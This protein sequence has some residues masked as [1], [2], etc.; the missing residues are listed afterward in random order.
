[1]PSGEFSLGGQLEAGRLPARL[2]ESTSRCA[3]ER[4]QHCDDPSLPC[5]PRRPPPPAGSCP[6]PSPTSS[7]RFCKITLTTWN[8]AAIFCSRFAVRTIALAKMAR[9]RHLLR[10]ADVVCIQEAHGQPGDLDTLARE[11]PSHVHFGTFSTSQAAGG[12]LISLSNEFVCGVNHFEEIV[13]APGWCLALRCSGPQRAIQFINIHIEPALSHLAKSKLLADIAATADTFAGSTYLL[14][15]FN[16]VPSDEARYRMAECEDVRGDSKLALEFESRFCGF[17]ELHQAGYTRKQVTH[18]AITALSRLDRIYTNMQPCLLHD[19]NVHT[20]T[21]GYITDPTNI[22]D[23]IPVTTC[24][25]PQRVH[26]GIDFRLSSWT[27][28]HPEFTATTRD[29]LDTCTLPASGIQSLSILREVLQASDMA[30]KNLGEAEGASTTPQ[31]LYWALMAMRGGRDGKPA[32]ISRAVGAYPKLLEWCSPRPAAITHHTDLHNHITLLSSSNIEQMRN[33]LEADPS[34]AEWKK[35]GR[36]EALRRRA[37]AWASSRR[38]TSTFTILDQ[39]EA[40]ATSAG[41]ASQL[42]ANHW[43]AVF[44]AKRCFKIAQEKLLQFVV[45]APDDIDWRLPREEFIAIAQR[46][47]DSAPGPD[48]IPY[49][50]WVQADP[51]FIDCVHRAYDELLDGAMLPDDFND[52]H[53]VFLPKGEYDGDVHGIARTPEATRPLTL[54]N[55]VAKVL[56][57]AMN[58]SLSQMAAR[59]VSPRQRGFV[60]GRNLLDNVVETEA[61]AIHFAQYYGDTS[62]IALL[63]LVAAFPSL[64]HSWIFAVLRRMGVPRFF[65]RA[66]AKLYRMVNIKILFGGILAAGFTASS[67]IKQGCPASGSLF[68]IAL[69]PFLRMLCLRLPMPVSIVSAFADDIGIVTRQLLETLSVLAEL[70]ALLKTATAM[71][72]SPTKSVI[73]PLGRQTEEIITD[74][75]QEHHP[76]LGGLLIRSHGKYLGFMVGPSADTARWDVAAAKFW[77]R[78]MA[79]R[80]AGGGFFLNTLQY[81]I[82]ATSVLSYLMQFSRLPK[83]VLRMEARILQYLTHGPWNAIPSSCLLSLCDVGFPKE[84]AS[85]EEANSAA[86]LRAAVTS[87]AFSA[88]AGMLDH[89]PSDPQ[90]LLAPRVLPWRASTAVFQMRANLVQFCRKFPSFVMEPHGTLQGRAKAALRAA[91][92]SPWDELLRRRTLRWFPEGAPNAV[93]HVHCNLVAACQLL[94]PRVVFSSVRLIANGVST[95]RRYQQAPLDCH[96]CGWVEGDCIEHYLHCEVFLGFCTVNLPATGWRFGPVHGT[97]RCMLCIELTRAELVATVVANDI[98]VNTLVTLTQGSIIATPVQLM[99]ARLRALSRSSATVRNSLT[100]QFNNL[101]N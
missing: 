65:R 21:V 15:D 57:S 30:I 19:L 53:M 43:G 72:L 56:A 24:I 16:F 77:Q 85:L 89:Q 44:T 97:L 47:T 61:A 39:G 18:D 10:H 41:H 98:L 83:F 73:I 42:L 93:E 45:A 59:T 1:V 87:K 63:D 79:A 9:Y 86:M 96:L 94:P 14:G 35:I 67:G 13:L 69:D 78:G 3:A 51:R 62:G 100:V 80:D 25:Q 38:R 20:H 76:S 23:H 82:Y 55:A 92:Q 22:S 71:G 8:A 74:H 29:M 49:S 54:S 36:R 81:S 4:A 95:A 12:L 27:V 99:A 91:R 7:Q 5:D 6:A 28:K 33:E 75:I 46:C 64:A 26:N 70:L 50:A 11:A 68:A 2:P 40:P 90:A 31:K 32:L 58:A 37:T 17:T 34:I 101:D 66:L 52:A 88:A 84:P 48:G 60:R